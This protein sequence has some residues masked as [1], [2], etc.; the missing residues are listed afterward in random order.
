MKIEVKKTAANSS[1]IILSDLGVIINFESNHF[2]DFDKV[3]D[4]SGLHNLITGIFEK[5]LTESE[6]RSE[7]QNSIHP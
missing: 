7:N 4:I 1:G 2:S 3:G 6:L 5:A